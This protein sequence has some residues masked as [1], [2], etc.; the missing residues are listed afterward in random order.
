MTCRLQQPHRDMGKPHPAAP[1]R[2]FTLLSCSTQVPKGEA[3]LPAIVE[4]AQN[5][6]GLLISIN[7]E[8][9]FYLLSSFSDSTAPD[10]HFQAFFQMG[11]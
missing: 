8:L 2:A 6:R 5:Q 1:G 4:L 7:I 9:F 11:K 3:W 10:S